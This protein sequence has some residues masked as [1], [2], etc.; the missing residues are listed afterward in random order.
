VPTRAQVFRK[1]RVGNA[2]YIL[3]RA[4]EKEDIPKRESIGEPFI[5]YI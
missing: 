5:L 3:K 1:S 4:A 2:G